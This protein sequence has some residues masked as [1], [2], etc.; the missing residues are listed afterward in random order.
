MN[1]AIDLHAEAHRGAIEVENVWTDR[2]LP[3]EAK[4]CKPALAQM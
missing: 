2:M 1:E 4:G 3:P